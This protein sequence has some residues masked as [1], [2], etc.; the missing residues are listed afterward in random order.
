MTEAQRQVLHEFDSSLKTSREADTAISVAGVLSGVK[1]GALIEDLQ[2]VV[3]PER[4]K[5]MGIWYTPVAMPAEWRGQAGVISRSSAVADEL[6]Q[7]VPDRIP[8]PARDARIGE[9]LGF[10][11]S[12][13]AHYSKRLVTYGT[14]GE[15]PAGQ[16]DRHNDTIEFY[17]AQLV[18]S[19]DNYN[20]EM[21]SYVRPL[22]KATQLLTPRA[23]KILEDEVNK[24]KNG[25]LHTMAKSIL[26]KKD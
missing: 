19:P 23:Y 12:A 4:F 18:L 9:L 1:P 16:G 6:S 22:Q 10:P 5:K 20:E 15:L 2:N 21:E 24:H 11:P 26:K 25:L 7:I 17:F 3:W 13:T 8:D 14:P